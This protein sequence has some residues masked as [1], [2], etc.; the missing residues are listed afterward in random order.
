MGG[1]EAAN[2]TQTSD[3]VQIATYPKPTEWTDMPA[4]D[5][6][7]GPRMPVPAQQHKHAIVE[8]ILSA[9]RK[10]HEV[11]VSQI[12]RLRPYLHLAV[13]RLTISSP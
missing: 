8:K 2:P 10:R 1:T 13:I 9:L 3:A 11:T 6:L 7:Y 12:I 4:L 5:L